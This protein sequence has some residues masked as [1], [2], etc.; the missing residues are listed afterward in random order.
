MAALLAR[1]KMTFDGQTYATEERATEIDIGGADNEP[2]LDSSGNTHT[3]EKLQPG[4]FKCTLLAIEGF[5]LRPVQAM[6]NGT[7]IAE[8]NNGLSFMM[9]NAKCGQAR[10]I[11]S[12]GKISATFYG[13]VEEM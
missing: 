12:G 3:A 9:R 4:M 13:D 11:A 5:K 1:L 6:K 10:S 8:G 7:I 2:V